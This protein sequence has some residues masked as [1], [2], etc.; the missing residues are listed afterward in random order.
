MKKNISIVIPVYNEELSIKPLYLELKQVLFENFNKYEIIF[1]NDGS[2]DDS[3]KII[4]KEIL[5][6]T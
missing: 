6:I 5:N 2:T 4:K 1:I 3:V